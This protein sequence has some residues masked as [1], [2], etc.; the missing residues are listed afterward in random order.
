MDVGL[1]IDVGSTWTKGLAVDL[2]AGRLIARTQHPTTLAAGIMTGVH[3]VVETL[4]GQHG[5][6]VQFRAASSSA[7]GGLRV[8]A[9]GL[10][11]SLTGLAARQASLG[12]GARV[13]FSGNFQLAQQE[14][15]SLRAARPD[16][17]LLAGGTDGGNREV[18]VRNA[19]LLADAG[20]QA[21]VI[22]A[23]NKSAREEVC[24]ILARAGLDYRVAD[25]VLPAID[26]MDVSGAQAAIR[27]VFL[28]K[29][30]VARGIE[31]L[32]E[33]AGG[34][35]LPTPRAVLDAAVFLSGSGDDFRSLVLVDIGGATTDVHSIG[36]EE[37][38]QG[39]LLRGL[40]EPH[41]K[42]TVEGDLGLRVSAL[43]ATQALGADKLSAHLG[44][45]SDELIARAERL[46]ADTATL[47][48]QEDFDRVVTIAAVAEALRRHAGWLE[49]SPIDHRTWFQVGKDLRDA[50]AVIASGGVFAAREDARALI[51]AALEQARLSDRLVPRT[52]RTWVDKDYVMFA[53][54][55][56]S[57]AHR[58]AALG[59]AM[60][61]L[62]RA[63][64][65]EPH[66]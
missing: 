24:A 37:P 8:A 34:L 50:S 52:A 45:S 1:L 60:K 31:E 17:V 64:C 12:A 11:P 54:G 57:G 22:V 6:T 40:R 2:G 42:R 30:V 32:R 21:T 9:I 63:A 41:A 35:L 5:G 4:D 38:A 44:G 58:D 10:V 47:H 23:G 28:E 51:D 18:I 49:Q 62:G 61:S 33:W 59:L 13:V 55:L 29:I 16:I 3:A 26:A 48:A 65:C 36:G 7:A 25:N 56:L 27:E 14:I 66:S 20:V 43:A 46:T 39:T 19:Q 15:D 53:V